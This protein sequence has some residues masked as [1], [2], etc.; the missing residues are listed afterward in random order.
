MGWI[1][2]G[3]PEEFDIDD[4]LSRFPRLI[5]W[6]TPPGQGAGNIST[7]DRVFMWRSGKEAGAIA[8]GTVEELPTLRDRVKH[9]E[10][11]PDALLIKGKR[12]P[13]EPVT[14]I[15]IEQLRLTHSAHMI[16]RSVVKASPAFANTKLIK[17]GASTVFE[18]SE[19][20]TKILEKLWGLEAQ[21]EL[22][23]LDEPDVL[24]DEH[25][26]KI[27]A[28]T[29]IDV[30]TKDQLIKSRRGQGRFKAN[31]GCNETRCRVTG[32]TDPRHLRASHIKPWRDS[33]DDEKLSGYNGLL[34]APHVDHL[35]DRGLISFSDNGDLLISVELDRSILTKWSISEAINVGLFSVHQAAFLEYHR[36]SVFK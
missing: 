4:Y 33:T 20:Q 31:V 2:Q 29:D 19:E 35:F 17:V 8:I 25:E 9:P 18:L 7:G 5:Y 13:A 24:E 16:H 22:D 21:N 32:V 14:G 27:K 34:L 11:L 6:R 10:A 12:D 23:E 3:K 28:R 30:T 36:C 15:R 26:E 1:F